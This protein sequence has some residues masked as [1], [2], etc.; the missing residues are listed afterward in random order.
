V[1]H[2]EDDLRGVEA[3]LEHY[4]I[5]ERDTAEVATQDATGVRSRSI[6]LG[7]VGWLMD[8]TL[9]ITPIV[10]LAVRGV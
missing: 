4:P 3:C 2:P 9:D 10:R 8:L 5:S 1:R 6:A 7:L